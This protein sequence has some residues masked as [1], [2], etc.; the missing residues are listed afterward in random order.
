MENK[1]LL[2]KFLNQISFFTDYFWGTGST[3]DWLEFV[4]NPELP[5]YKVGICAR[6]LQESFYE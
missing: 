1:I 2:Y 5:E 4:K 3:Y 6:T